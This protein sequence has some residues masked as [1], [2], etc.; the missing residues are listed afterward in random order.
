MQKVQKDNQHISRVLYWLNKEKRPSHKEV[1]KEA[2]YVR[3][4]LA[5]WSQLCF[6]EGLLYRK[7]HLHGYETFQLVLPH[8]L[9]QLVLK[10][11]HDAAGHQRVEQPVALVQNRCYRPDF[12]QRC[13]AKMLSLGF[14]TVIDVSLLKT[15]T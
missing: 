8:S 14:K 3:K 2:P 12:S 1:K 5:R 6:K 10:Y 11:L 4:L 7:V 13:L 9:E 15:H